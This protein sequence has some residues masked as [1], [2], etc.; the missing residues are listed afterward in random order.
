MLQEEEE[1][2]ICCAY[3]LLCMNIHEYVQYVLFMYIF[4]FQAQC[5]S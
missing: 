1:I 3:T 4:I 5:T 2:V